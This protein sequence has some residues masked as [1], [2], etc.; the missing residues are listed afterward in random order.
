M[1]EVFLERIWGKKE[2]VIIELV[3]VRNGSECD[4]TA[5]TIKNGI[6]AKGKANIK[7][8]LTK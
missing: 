1:G 3:T 8:S 4:L 2:L 7:V 5:P 6:T